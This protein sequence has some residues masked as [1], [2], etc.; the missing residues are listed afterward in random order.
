M[1]LGI[2]EICSQE[3]PPGLHVSQ[4]NCVV[5]AQREGQQWHYDSSVYQCH[6]LTGCVMV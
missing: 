4:H 1:R 2:L 3:L 6:V 5:K